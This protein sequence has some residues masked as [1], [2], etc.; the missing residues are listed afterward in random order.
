[1]IAALLILLAVLD[2]SP[3]QGSP[4]PWRFPAAPVRAVTAPMAPATSWPASPGIAPSEVITHQVFFPWVARMP[5]TCEPIP[6]VQYST[7]DVDGPPSFRPAEQHPDLNLA[8]R[9]YEVT[10]AYRGLV[11]Y[12][13]AGDPKAP[14]LDSLFAAH[15]VPAFST[16]YRVYDWD[17]GCDC[18]GD[19]LELY[20]VTLVGMGT[21][22][23]EALHLPDSGYNIGSGYEALVLYAAEERITLKYTRE[24][25][26]VYG[27]T[28]HLENVC[29]EPSLL[30]L[31]RAWND[32]GRA[33]L[34]A[35]R[36]G[37]PLGR[38]RG[39]EIGVAVRD[40]GTFM[41]PR[42]RGDWWQGE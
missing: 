27:Y 31:Y 2:G 30:A 26:V 14:Q 36:G 22:P 16:T 35:L 10:N 19:L 29:V 41:D 15:R 39:D 40:S 32:A 25:H 13:G 8:L 5:D 38:A 37:Q 23:G 33:R 7:L 21:V 12:G 18:R 11:D 20:D 9:G 3:A 34:P 17:W 4:P 42:T 24:D 6:G 28:L 1:M